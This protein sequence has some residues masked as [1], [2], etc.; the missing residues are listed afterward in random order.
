[1]VLLAT[2]LCFVAIVSST[3]IRSGARLYFSLLLVLE[4]ALL[5]VFTALDWS[6]FYVC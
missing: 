6:L 4:T 3:G 1:M 2:L 5:I